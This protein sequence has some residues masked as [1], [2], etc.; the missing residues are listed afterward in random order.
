MKKILFILL[1]FYAIAAFGQEFKTT[2]N[3]ITFDVKV[4]SSRDLTVEIIRS[5]NKIKGSSIIIPDEV[6]YNS[7]IYTVVSIG[8]EAFKGVKATMIV[9]PKHLRNISNK[10]FCG[11]SKLSQIDFPS[12]LEN[13]GDEAFRGCPIGDL[14]FPSSIKHIGEKAFF[15]ENQTIFKSR[16][17]GALFIPKTLVSLGEH[18]FNSFRNGYGI[19]STSKRSIRCLPDFINKE[20]IKKYGIHEDSYDEYMINKK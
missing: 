11:C 12:E 16:A 7:D 14:I 1:S 5:K 4:M 8:E 6:N 18:A 13:I 15:S 9:L 17:N 10:A 3:G 19:W 2:E 20:N